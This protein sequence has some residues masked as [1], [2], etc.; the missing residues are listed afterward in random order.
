MT[1][2]HAARR[3]MVESQVRPN[4]IT[5]GRIIEAM[6]AV[7]RERF[8]PDELRSIAYADEA[9]PL[10]GGRSL[11]EPMA[12]ARLLQLARLGESDRAL[13][14]GAATGYGAA[15]MSHLAN[16]VVALE[17]DAVLAGMARSR[18]PSFANVELAEGPLEDGWR[19]GAPYDAI[20]IAGRIEQLPDRL[21]VQLKEGGRL[22]AAHGTGAVARA[23]V[24]TKSASGLSCRAGFDISV[25][26]LSAFAAKKPAFVF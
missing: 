6:A 21:A 10:P 14:I 13:L 20:V 18:L 5:D 15:V 7:E 12:L 3:N 25:A 11:M 19:T 2:F 1:D 8:V 4:G 24:W 16:S 22:V 17:V 23:C 9:I 26:P